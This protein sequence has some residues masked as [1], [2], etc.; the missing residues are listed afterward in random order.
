MAMR[1]PD[2]APL[3]RS[4]IGLKQVGGDDMGKAA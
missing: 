1:N 3:S 4:T 2:F